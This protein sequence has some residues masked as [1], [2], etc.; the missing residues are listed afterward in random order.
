VGSSRTEE[1]YVLRA[2]D[3]AETVRS[4]VETA[5]L[6]VDVARRDR[7]L[8]TYLSVL[9]GEAGTDA[10][11]AHATF[12][13]VQPPDRHQDALRA[14]LGTVL[15]HA[16]D[17]LSELRIRTRRGEVPTPPPARSTPASPC[18]TAS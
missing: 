14:E 1:D 3:T 11:A 9:V 6:A 8:P 5:R 10:A 15:T 17:L 4:A 13:S 12:D 2:V 18:S 16:D 7:V